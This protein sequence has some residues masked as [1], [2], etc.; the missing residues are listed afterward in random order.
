MK[1]IT[2]ILLITLFW[3]CK[4]SELIGNDISLSGEIRTQL[5]DVPVNATLELIIDGQLIS[6]IDSTFNGEFKFRINKKHLNK[7]GLIMVSNVKI[8]VGKME[9]TPTGFMDCI[10]TT[11]SIPI[12]INSH[13]VNYNIIIEPCEFK[14]ISYPSKHY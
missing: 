3:S 8:I 14:V 1:I 10:T 2:S 7:D 11:D 12:S 4:S 13:D 5:G 9:F 6:K